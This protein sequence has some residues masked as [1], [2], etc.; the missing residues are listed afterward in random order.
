M[1]VD[2]VAQRICLCWLR[3][4]GIVDLAKDIRSICMHPR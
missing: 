1:L 2:K 3:F 4:K